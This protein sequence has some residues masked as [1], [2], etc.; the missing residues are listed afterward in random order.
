MAVKL[1]E[2][3]L[4]QQQ[5]VS[6]KSFNDSKF[7][8]LSQNLEIFVLIYQCVGDCNYFLSFILKQGEPIFDDLVACY[9]KKSLLVIF[10]RSY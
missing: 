6:V 5:Q 1:E 2:R 9:Q 4:L 7:M 3:G 10:I 8:Q